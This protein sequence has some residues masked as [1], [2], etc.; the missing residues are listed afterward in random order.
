MK[1][2]S[3]VTVVALTFLEGAAF[4]AAAAAA[5]GAGADAEEDA[6]DAAV[7]AGVALRLGSAL[8][9]RSLP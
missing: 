7:G 3:T 4:G 1:V 8:T 5:A 6:A 2:A 9:V